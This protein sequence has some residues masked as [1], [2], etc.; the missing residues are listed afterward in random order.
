MVSIDRQR[1]DW[2]EPARRR[3]TALRR[4]LL[5][6]TR[7]GW[8]QPRSTPALAPTTTPRRSPPRRFRCGM[9]R[10]SGTA[11]RGSPRTL[12][13]RGST[14][15]SCRQRRGRRLGPPRHPPCPERRPSNRTRAQHDAHWP[16]S[17]WSHVSMRP[18]TRSSWRHRE[19]AGRS[20]AR[21]RDSPA[22]GGRRAAQASHSM[23]DAS[24]SN[25][26]RNSRKR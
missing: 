17:P 1:T 4:A 15:T 11:E 12:R 2:S 8:P 18:H 6:G 13:A 23:S 19:P 16:E 22:D 25:W 20:I 10:G 3:V 26:S 5:G 14:R 9:E 7:R 24:Y 21:S